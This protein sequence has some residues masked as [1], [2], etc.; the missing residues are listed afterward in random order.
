VHPSIEFA[1]RGPTPPR[2]RV[3]EY[4]RLEANSLSVVLRIMF[5]GQPVALLAADLDA[6]AL[7]HIVDRVHPLDA[8]V[9][10]FP[11]HGG[12]PGTHDPRQFAKSLM[13]EVDPKLVIF[14]ISGDR[15][16]ANP[17]LEILDGVRE[18]V[19]AAH[20]ACTQLSV[21]CHTEHG[22]VDDWH[23]ARGHAAGRA[24]RRCCAGTVTITQINGALAFDPPLDRHQAFVSEAVMTPRC[25]SAVFIPRQTLSGIADPT[26]PV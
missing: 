19:P 10:V 5:D 9:L 11:H 26:R 23:L 3:P 25:A 16:A 1:G 4:G 2:Q 15:R 24:E 13:S 22:Q 21:H 17:R 12:L 8:P 6:V 20:I 7:Q 18:A 14:S